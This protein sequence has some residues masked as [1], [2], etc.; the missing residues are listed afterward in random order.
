MPPTIFLLSPADVKATRAK[1]MMSPRANFSAAVAYR[2]DEGVA[3][4]DAFTFMS[5]LY[6]RGKIAYAKRFANPPAGVGG[7]IYVIAPGF[8]LVHPS[9]RITIKTMKKLQRTPV[10]SKSRAYTSHLVADAKALAASI[11]PDTRVVLLGSIATGKY[12]DLLWPIFGERLLFPISFVGIGDM[13]R[14][15][16]MLKAAASDVELEYSTLEVERH[17]KRVPRYAETARHSE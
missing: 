13:S 7:G 1:Q 15:S 8:G 4:E 3:I 10:D 9:W 16:I 11:T 5:Q 6:F 12:V 2:S 17:R 14:G